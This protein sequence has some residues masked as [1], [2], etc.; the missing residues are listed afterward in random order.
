M[1]IIKKWGS[2]LPV[3]MR[4]I[5]ITD[6]DVL[7]MGMGL[8]STPY[9]HWACFNKRKLVS[10]D[11]E[12]EYFNM[13][14]EYKDALHEVHFVDDWDKADIEK[15]WDLAL[16]D[17]GPPERRGEDIMRLAN[18]VKYIIVHDTHWKQ[19]KHYHYKENVF[20]FFKYRYDYEE[21]RPT[22]TVLSNLVDLKDFQVC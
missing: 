1:L 8:Y 2:H 6:G 9:L 11:N 21:V 7:E 18:L 10:Y 22:T 16:I 17:H 5:S 4:I 13:N 19:D 12:P 20:P 15:P 14:K 3:L